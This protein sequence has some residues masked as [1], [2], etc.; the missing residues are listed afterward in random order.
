MNFYFD[1]QNEKLETMVL[2][3]WAVYASGSLNLSEASINSHAY[4]GQTFHWFSVFV[5]P[6]LI[7]PGDGLRMFL[8]KER[9]G[10]S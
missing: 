8:E 1:G 7:V 10:Q 3:Q 9:W 4:I 5:R 6:E 2:L